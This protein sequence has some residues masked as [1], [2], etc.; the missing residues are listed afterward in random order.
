MSGSTRSYEMARRLVA[1]GHQVE[2]ITS[3]RDATDKRDWFVTHEEGIRVHWLPVRYSNHLGYAQRIRAFLS[4]ALASASRAAALPADV[5]L[6]SS[7]PLTIALSAIYAK[8]RRGVPLV[9]EVRDLWPEVPIAMGALKSPV[10][11]WLAR[12]LE[13]FAYANSEAIVA[14]SP[15]MKAGML[16]RGVSADK[17]SVIP[18]GSDLRSGRRGRRC[19]RAH[20]SSTGRA[21]RRHPGGLSRHIGSGK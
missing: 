13:K 16:A 5:V 2:M 18:N 15:G 4:Y 20:Q 1:A 21:R 3:W 7:T 17:V 19:A 11:R 10:T 6:A 9:F 14:L 8:W 12:R